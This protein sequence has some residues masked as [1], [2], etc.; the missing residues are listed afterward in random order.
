MIA[1]LDFLTLLVSMALVVAAISPAV[2]ILLFILDWKG[3]KLW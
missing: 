1:S 3:K 2:L